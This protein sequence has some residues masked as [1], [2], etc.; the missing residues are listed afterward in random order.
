M[1]SI[2]KILLVLAVCALGV[3]CN[4]EDLS[5]GSGKGTVQVKV[6][7]DNAAVRSFSDSDGLKWEAGDQL[8]YAGGIELTS[9]PLTAEN[10]SEDGRIANFTFDA[11]LTEVDRTG[12]FCS[13]KCHPTNY[14][15]VE[16][17][18]G[19]D[20]GNSF[21]QDAAG[22]MNSRYIFLHSG[23]GLTN[24]VKDKPLEITAEIAGSIF[25]VLPYTTSYNEEKVL[26]VKLS[27]NTKLVGTVAYD[28]GGSSYTGVNELNGG[29]GWKAYDFV[30]ANLGIPLSL[31]GV[32]D[33]SSSKG[34]YFA[35][36]AT[37]EDAPLE[38]YR[39][40]VETDKADYVFDPKDKQL[41]VANNVVKNV[42][43]NL[44]KAERQAAPEGQLKYDGE[45]NLSSI[46]ADGCTDR[47]AGYWQA[48]TSTDGEQWTPML[49]SEN[50]AFYNAVTFDYKDADGNPQSWL[51]VRYG[52]VDLRHW[53]VS[54][55][56]NTG[57]ERSVT[58]TAHFADVKGYKIQEAS[59]TKSWTFTQ[60]A[61]GTAKKVGYASVSLPDGIEIKGSSITDKN[62][63]YCLL[64][65]DGTDNRDWS[66]TGIYARSRF[67]YVSEENYAARNYVT[68]VDWL[69][70][71]YPDNGTA[72]TDCEW[73]VS[74]AANDSE[75]DRTA[76]VVCLFPEDDAYEFPEPRALKVTQK[77]NTVV[78][79]SFS[80]IYAETVPAEGGV[81][82]AGKLSLSING[83]SQT[84]VAAAIQQYG[85][86]LSSDK[87]SKVTVASDGAVSMT[88]PANPYKNGGVTYTV[89]LVS[90]GVVRASMTV[91][92]EEGAEE[93]SA[94]CIYTYDLEIVNKNGFGYP[95][96]QTDNNA[97]W[98]FIRN[99][100][101]DG[102]FVELTQEIAEEVLAF[103]YRGTEP[104]E[105]EKAA[106]NQSAKQSSATAV[107]PRVRWFGGVQIDVALNSGASGQITK[108]VGYNPDGTEFGSF[109]V[110]ID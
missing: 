89:K 14:T 18:L 80:D 86:S 58:V 60:A 106:H 51:S 91:S 100:K 2:D 37:K 68:D 48:L 78:E 92:Q 1:K 23:T 75:S 31:Q 41:A 39:Y 45:L 105:E 61:A 108:I 76:Y 73:L 42:F 69:S 53:I 94:S 27:S 8:K 101:K 104:T 98:A 93:G 74:A 52:G 12:W 63:G 22:E 54:A 55:G 15:E 96:N 29:A 35:V 65:V 50:L 17:T 85:L 16:F 11:R 66:E 7:I 47:D 28:R 103:A 57:E 5:D 82:T 88:V 3:S 20:N 95:A 64:N 87:G 24:V 34:I 6:A 30:K 33:A 43:L 25:R 19:A 46:P 83:V 67:V 38:G 49:N 81:I 109:I 79:A 102:V 59:L 84:D 26:S 32:N 71:R 90:D 62:V 107:E 4:K 10:I 72:I 56:A 99:V 70:C 97:N 36:A 44:D 9:E 77:T 110:W 21:M 40:V 13:T